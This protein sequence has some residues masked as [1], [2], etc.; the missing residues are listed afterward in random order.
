MAIIKVDIQK[1]YRILNPGA[2][3]LVSAKYDGDVNAMA[4]TWAQALDY[5]KVTIVPH[6]SSCAGTLIEKSG[7]FA[8]QIPTAAQAELVS[9]PGAENNSRFDNADKMKNVEI[10]YQDDS[11]VPLIAD[12]A[13]WLVFKR[14]PEPHNE[15]S[16]DLFIGEVVAAYADE[17]I[18]DGGHWLFEKTSDELK[19][20]HY[21]VGRY[22]LDGKA[23]D[24]KH[25]PIGEE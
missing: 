11:R 4:I 17:R 9:E 24:T 12:C 6:N 14:I 2:T 18:F 19:T 3:T 21:V 1:S 7:Y 25:T 15:Q 16:Y 5:D 8:V 20:L 10:F 23:V 13:A 22:Y